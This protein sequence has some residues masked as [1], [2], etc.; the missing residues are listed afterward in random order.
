MMNLTIIKNQFLKSFYILKNNPKYIVFSVIFDLL[1]FAIY[2]VVSLAI[3]NIITDKSNILLQI[4]SSNKDSVNQLIAEGKN[5][6]QAMMLQQDFGSNFKSIIFLFFTL[7]VFAYLTYCLFQGINWGIGREL[8]GSKFKFIEFMKPFFKIN[9]LLLIIAFVSFI[10]YY[11][12]ISLSFNNTVMMVM[13]LGF[14]FFI[15]V[16]IWVSKSG[17]SNFMKSFFKINILW[18]A[19]LYLGMFFERMIGIL[20]LLGGK[21]QDTGVIAL[22]IAVIIAYF[23]FI[24]YALIGKKGAIKRSFSSGFKKFLIFVPVYVIVALVFL[25]INYILIFAQQINYILMV[26]LGFL[27][28][29][30]ALS[31]ARVFI[32]LIV[33]K[34]DKVKNA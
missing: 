34:T 15:S 21:K 29:L 17:F 9:I 2:G 32:C 5:L 10:V 13:V 11:T 27:L 16:L 24:S 18:F 33:N 30:P 23:A 3:F 7:M 31:W 28:F 12:N 14:L 25:I 8:T 1:F 6:F 19:L 26:V 22:I 20:I 4:A